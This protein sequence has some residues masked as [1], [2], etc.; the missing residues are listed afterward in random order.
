MAVS[1]G[2][3]RH[4]DYD[5]TVISSDKHASYSQCGIPY[6]LAGEITNF[7]KLLRRE[8]KFFMDMG[9]ELRL[10][11]MVDSIDL[12]NRRV[13]IGKEQLPFN[14]LVIAT[15]SKPSIPKNLESGTLLKNVFT[16]RT[17]SDGMQID[18]A[19][20]NAKDLVIIGA[21]S[22][23]TEVAIA[24]AHRGIRTSLLNRS[25]TILSSSFDPDM[26]EMVISYL[27][28]EGVQVF[29]KHVPDIH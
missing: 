5:V 11:T 7:S 2:A 4:S 29:T 20:N 22:I 8:Y 15:G 3:R 21:G 27:E 1:T 18:E 26:A 19:L 28:K 16:L 13:K 10:D 6:V 12:E 14:K 25:D 23:G 17:L 24:A 9:I